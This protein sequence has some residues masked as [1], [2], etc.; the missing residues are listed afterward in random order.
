MN[1]EKK[2]IVSVIEPVG[3]HGGMNYYDINLCESI[4]QSNLVDI[5]LY[6][7][8]ETKETSNLF[9]IKKV[10]KGVYGQRSKYIR[11]MNFIKGL[12]IALLSSKKNNV[13][14]FHFH[15]FHYTLLELFS[16]LTAKILN[17]KVVIT[18][19][20][21]E[22]FSTGSSMNI[23][24][25]IYSLSDGIIAHNNVSKNELIN[26]VGIKEDKVSVI[27]H[28]NYLSYVNSDIEKEEALRSLGIPYNEEFILLFFGQIK[29]VKGL[30]ILIESIPEI[31][32]NEKNIKV[33]IAG[34]VWKDDFSVYQEKIDRLDINKYIISHIEYIPE[35]KVDLYF[36]AADL[37][38]LPYKKI[39]QSGV[40]LNA[41]SYKKSVVVS[42]LDG[43]KE[44]IT[45]KQNGFLFKNGDAI[46]LANVVSGI[47]Y[48][49]RELK[50]IS[51]SAY[52]YIVNNH[53]W[54]D[55]GIRTSNF[56]SDL[57]RK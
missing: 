57:L 16:V 26:T 48:K 46:D 13:D 17:V 35:D 55:I 27:P 41:M 5:K 7:S 19:H 31:V 1:S 50:E 42:D 45:N 2:V 36:N 6:T 38:V 14:I 34:K 33:I 39:Y 40:L 54:K 22:S 8:D 32:K 9:N 49:K 24:R 23:A 37:V 21:V 20:D 18:A 44:I 12:I 28:G 53:D 51:Q 52:E 30:D 3:G 25:K 47:I 29:T 11:G 15:F 56:Y 4:Q 43:M 10:F